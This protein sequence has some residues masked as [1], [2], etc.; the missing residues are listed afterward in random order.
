ML[1][2]QHEAFMLEFQEERKAPATGSVA[3]TL[4]VN[5]ICDALRAELQK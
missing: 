4:K 3:P 1:Q 2:K 5:K